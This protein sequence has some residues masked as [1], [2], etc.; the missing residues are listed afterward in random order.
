MVLTWLMWG[1][2]VRDKSLKIGAQFLRDAG[3]WIQK[4]PQVVYAA[5]AS[6]WGRAMPWGDVTTKDKS[7]FLI[8]FD[9]PQDGKLYLPGLKKKIVS[10]NLL[11]GTKT[12]KITFKN[13]SDWTIFNVPFQPADNPASVI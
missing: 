13:E 12:E 10:A 3:K 6:P 8:V 7:V 1:R 11:K 9:W 4:Y 2:T 5:G